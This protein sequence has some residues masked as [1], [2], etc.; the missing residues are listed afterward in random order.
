MSRMYIGL[1]LLICLAAAASSEEVKVKE[2]IVEGVGMTEK[3]ALKD[4][5][6]AAVGQVVGTFVSSETLVKNE[7]L[8]QD[9]ILTASDGFVKTH[10]VLRSRKDG[11]QV[12]VTV[13]VVVMREQLHARL[14][15]FK[16][17][18]RRRSDRDKGFTDE[19][20]ERLTKA[21]AGKHKTELLH[22]VLLD[23]PKVLSV[24]SQEFGRL[25]YDRDREV[26]KVKVDVEGDAAAYRKFLGRLQA[27]LDKISQGRV[28][29][30]FTATAT[31]L[32]A[33]WGISLP[34]AKVGAWGISTTD[35][36]DRKFNGPVLDKLPG[37][38][39]LWVL[40]A[41]SAKHDR[42]RWTG[43]VLD[44]DPGKV[45][46]AV[47]GELSV[48][49]ELLDAAGKSITAEKFSL[50]E[51]GTVHNSWLGRLVIRPRE[52]AP[53]K[54]PFTSWP[55]LQAA[56]QAKP[57]S[58]YTYNAYVGP[59]LFPYANWGGSK[60]FCYAVMRTYAREVTLTADEWK[61]LKTIRC[62]LEF[63]PSKAKD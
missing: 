10:K 44:A 35:G 18:D 15:E 32:D 13:R 11:T 33:S 16:I 61:R 45:L 57:S 5:F 50:K 63:E 20:V 12:R 40:T 31:E 60:P 43:Y 6:R 37:S 25:D 54:G 8:I 19:E 39:C 42:T 28:N 30:G 48:K 9:K 14:R 49:M 34:P 46:Q 17:G 58:E 38:W 62:R 7:K 56:P 27:R 21:E 41:S 55:L 3:E 47:Y 22:D 29:A 59:F 52:D 2:V 26:L 4:A 53:N 1:S 23:F 24:R 36:R 51:G